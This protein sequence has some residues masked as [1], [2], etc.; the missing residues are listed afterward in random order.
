MVSM[1]AKSSLVAIL[2][3]LASISVFAIASIDVQ[4]AGPGVLYVSVFPGDSVV[5]F[6]WSASWFSNGYSGSYQESYHIYRGLSPGNLSLYATK[7]YVGF[8]DNSVENGLIYYYKIVA[9]DNTGEGPSSLV[10]A[11]PRPGPSDVQYSPHD[12]PN[13]EAF[14]LSLSWT[15]PSENSSNV[16]AFKIY[17]EFGLPFVLDRNLTSTIVNIDSGWGPH[18]VRLSAVFADSRESFAPL[19]LVGGPMCEGGG[20]CGFCLLLL[21]GLIAVVVLVAIVITLY[22]FL[23]K[24]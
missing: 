7:D 5:D 19:I 21:I 8:T 17:P 1:A 2:L 14:D 23:R 3:A 11:M 15:M 16:T 4:A 10:N 9:F 13:C 18:G 20:D 24:R 6:E 12:V 22:F